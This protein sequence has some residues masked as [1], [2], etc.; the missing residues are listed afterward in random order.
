MTD[1]FARLEVHEG[2]QV[3]CFVEGDEAGGDYG[4]FLITRCDVGL[5][6]KVTEG[7]WPG[8]E[9]GWSAAEKALKDKDLKRFAM[10]AISAV[11]NFKGKD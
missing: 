7:P 2:S 1:I 8:T 3:L 4:P 6:V 10:S 11:K 5:T 9:D